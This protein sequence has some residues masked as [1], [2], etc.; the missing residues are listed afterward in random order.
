M[1]GVAFMTET[2]NSTSRPPPTEE[3]E[4]IRK[5]TRETG[6]SLMI[7]ALAGT[8]KT[9]TLELAGKEIKGPALALAFNKS[10]A[11]EL[12]KR[13]AANFET[14][15]MNGFGHGALMRMLPG[16]R[17]TLESRKLGKIV[18]EEAKRAGTE[19]SQDDWEDIRALAGKSQT[20]GIK[21][22]ESDGLIPDTE[23]EW[24]ALADDLLISEGDFPFVK[25]LAWETLRRNNEL[26]R[27]GLISFDDQVYYPTLYGG[28]FP[29]FPSILVDESQDLNPLNHE[30]LRQ[31]LGPKSR[32]LLCGDPRQ[33][34]YGFR[35]SVTDSMSKIRGMRDT[36]LDLPLTLTFRCPKRIVERQQRHAP[37]YRAWH[38]NPDGDFRRLAADDR[39]DMVE[40]EPLGW[41]WQSVVEALPAPKSSIVVLCRNNGPLLSLAFKLL[42]RGVSVVMLGRDI[43][44]GLIALSRKIE[45]NEASPIDIFLGKLRDW[46]E[47]ERSI[48]LAMGKEEK[49]AGVTDRAECLRAVAFG[50]RCRDAGELRAQLEKLFARESGSVTLGSI[51]RSKGLEWDCVL[52]LDP[53]R[54]PSKQARRAAMKGDDRA[55]KQEYNL[56][57]VAETRTRHTLIEANLEDFNVD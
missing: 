17:L 6:A 39:V 51:H 31:S 50:A 56:R 25:D 26:T 13:F 21:P 1:A 43:G 3:Q 14:K 11:T 55:L 48:A 33:S 10:I 24:K 12:A 28:R 29:I 40:G 34:I 18:T 32:L 20:A 35:G 30:M 9:T 15:T 2:R 49:V 52:H 37:G 46:E 27:T 41:N 23:E 5:A 36:W 47:S 16:V 42:A 54:V 7:D 45:K 38:L 44:K 4:E 57:Y 53:W 8:G 22:G 19:T